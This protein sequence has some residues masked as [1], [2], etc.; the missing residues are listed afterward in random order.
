V[1]LL[2]ALPARHLAALLLLVA[3]LLAP[4]P[5]D[6]QTA[7]ACSPAARRLTGHWTTTE[8]VDGEN[9][10]LWRGTLRLV[11]RG[12]RIVGRWEPAGGQPERLVAGS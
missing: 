1:I 4:R 2:R 8:T 11:Q 7:P 10:S 3:G 6:A 5:A 12:E 9:S